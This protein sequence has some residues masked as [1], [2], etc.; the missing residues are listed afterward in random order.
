MPWRGIQINIQ[1]KQIL[2]SLLKHY[3]GLGALKLA[4]VGTWGSPHH[5]PYKTLWK[6][7][8]TEQPSQVLLSMNG[9]ISENKVY[10]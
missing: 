7:R 6:V 9:K 10:Y 5:I 3:A 1:T 8:N 4:W 2:N